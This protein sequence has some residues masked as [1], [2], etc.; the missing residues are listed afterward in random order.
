M[1]LSGVREDC[2]RPLPSSIL[3]IHHQGKRAHLANVTGAGASQSAANTPSSPCIV[4]SLWFEKSSTLLHCIYKTDKMWG[5]FCL[6]GVTLCLIWSEGSDLMHIKTSE[7][8]QVLERKLRPP[9]FCHPCFGGLSAGTGIIF[10]SLTFQQETLWGYQ[11]SMYDNLYLH[12]FED[13]EAVSERETHESVWTMLFACS[14][15]LVAK[16]PSIYKISQ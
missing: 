13:S 16:Y 7:W 6:L 12:G 15:G 2:S 8:P 11:T 9:F 1:G 5:V 4:I 10:C 3:V 14:G